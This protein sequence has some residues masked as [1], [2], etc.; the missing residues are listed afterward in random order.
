M[1]YGG[2]GGDRKYLGLRVAHAGRKAGGEA[3]GLH[4]AEPSARGALSAAEECGMRGVAVKCIGIAQ[5]PDCEGSV[6]CR[7]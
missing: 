6:P 1:H 2:D 5:N 4:P 7:H 3:A